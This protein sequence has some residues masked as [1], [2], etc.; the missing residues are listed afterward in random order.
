MAFRVSGLPQ[1]ERVEG[2]A[3]DGSLARLHAEALAML[4][5]GLVALAWASPGASQVTSAG[6]G[7]TR[8]A[9]GEERPAPT[10]EETLISPN[11]V[12]FI[13]VFDV[14]EMTRE[15]RVSESGRVD[16]PLLADP[17]EVAGLTAE[18]AAEAIAQQCKK[19]GVLSRPE[20]SITIR[21][22]RVHAVAVAGA[23]K[24]PQIYPVFGRIS[25]QDL[26]LQAGGVADD[27][28]STVI[29][30]R[31][32]V[33]RRVL[34]APVGSAGQTGSS[35]AAP[36]RLTINLKKLLEKGEASSNVDVFPGDHVT[37]ERAGVVY[38]VG[39]VSHAGAFALSEA[40]QEMTVLRALALAGYLGPFAKGKKAILLRPNPSA[41][42]G[43]DQIPINLTA[44]L[45]GGAP[46]R[47]MQSNDILF[48]PDS[49][50]LKALHRGADAA[51][52]AAT[53]IAVG[54]VP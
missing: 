29:I 1:P 7:A 18:Q 16:F 24:N 45:K 19:A 9:G 33:A 41:P 13:Q 51:T 15:Y 14:A 26:L 35:S 40:R 3:E 39:A 32:D 20:I 48:V 43:R 34:D 2:R 21:E 46:D 38:V 11:D 28:G 12:L 4:L 6:G 22:S 44:M 49:N 30:T 36:E 10:S 47:S 27:A 52:M 42:S 25:L 53:W 54:V 23:V 8:S 17:V 50:M 5:A 31:G 37:V